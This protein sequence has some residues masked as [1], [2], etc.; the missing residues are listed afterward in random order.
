MQD[1][2]PYAKGGVY[3][4]C[5]PLIYRQTKTNSNMQSLTCIAAGLLM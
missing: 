4:Y 5:R 2:A 3:T 1:H